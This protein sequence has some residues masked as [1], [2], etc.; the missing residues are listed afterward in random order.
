MSG[1]ALRAALLLGVLLAALAG[2]VPRV[3]SDTRASAPPVP[4]AAPSVGPAGAPPVAGGPPRYRSPLSGLRVVRLFDPPLTQYAPGHRGVD[5][6]GAPGAAV[7]AAG[8]G[9][10]AFAG[11]VGG[12]GV[13]VLAH[14]DG[15]RTEYEPVR[16]T[17]AVGATVPIGATLGVLSG[18]H[19]G[20]A[21]NRCLHWGARRGGVYLNPLALLQAPGAVRLLPWI[22]PPAA[23]GGD[24][25]WPAPQG[26][27]RATRA[28]V[29]G[30]GAAG[31]AATLHTAESLGNAATLHNA[32]T[33]RPAGSTGA[34]PEPPG[35]PAGTRHPPDQARGCAC[36]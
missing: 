24:G 14:P 8:A 27:A 13:V 16:G 23:T 15:V 9:T 2:V 36:R 19:R 7:R 22:D 25:R 20:C 28:P 4:R 21:P 33:P 18:S 3:G 34:A 32:A 31:S 26:P 11:S 29:G 10:V 12:R 17:V 30:L 35:A 6:A 1:T 5:L